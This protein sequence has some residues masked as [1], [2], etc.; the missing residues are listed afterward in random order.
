VIVSH[1]HRF[2][3]LKTRKT[4]GTSVEIALSRLCGPDDV[5]TPISEADEKL[6]A[7]VGGRAPQNYLMP[8]RA[9]TA[10]EWATRIAKGRKHEAYNHMAAADV[11]RFVGEGVWAEYTKFTIVRNPWDTVISSY[12]WKFRDRPNERPSIHDF[13]NSELIR[14]LLRNY[15][16]FSIDGTV[17]ADELCHYETL[18]ADLEVTWQ[19]VGLPTPVDLPRAKGGTRADR[20]PYREVLSDAEAHEIAEKFAAELALTGYAY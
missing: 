19:R 7:E 18:A 1:T 16:T 17:V 8:A 15:E 13:L 11:R 3:F 10:R 5:I 14:R 9:Y 2:I 6:R 4:A 20:R 12:Y